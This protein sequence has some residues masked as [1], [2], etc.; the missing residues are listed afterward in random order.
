MKYCSRC[1]AQLVDDAIICIG[2]GR[3]VN[4]E[5][6]YS[7]VYQPETAYT[8]H[9]VSATSASSPLAKVA[10]A[11]MI[12][13]T[14]VSGAYTMGIALAWCLP[15]TLSY[16]HQIKS[17]EKVSVDFK[18]CSLLFVSTIAGILMLCDNG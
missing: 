1:G 16:A 9:Q 14:V 7:P 8:P 2:C 12:V 18:V 4:N 15:M 10:I 6:A 5:Q 11:L 17:G 13:G 3:L